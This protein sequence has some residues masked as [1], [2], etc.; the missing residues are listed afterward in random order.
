MKTW[1][2]SSLIPSFRDE[3]CN[4]N[5]D[6]NKKNRRIIDRMSNIDLFL[7]EDNRNIEIQT[8]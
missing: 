6:C 5:E 2:I 1:L 3:E 7:W 8:E 4:K